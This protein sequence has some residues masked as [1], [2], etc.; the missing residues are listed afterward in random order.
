MVTDTRTTAETMVGGGGVG[1]RRSAQTCRTSHRSEEVT[2][3]VA[4]PISLR[5]NAVHTMASQS[6]STCPA[7]CV[8]EPCMSRCSQAGVRPTGWSSAG[9]ANLHGLGSLRLCPGHLP[10]GRGPEVCCDSQAGSYVTGMRLLKNGQMCHVN[11]RSRPSTRPCLRAWLCW[12]VP[13]LSFGFEP[14]S[15]LCFSLG[16]AG[17]KLSIAAVSR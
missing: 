4:P 3:R 5:V 16:R 13:A 14:Q 10:G 9:N 11:V 8:S 6:C 12:S 7:G 17:E 2:P 15:Q 1:V